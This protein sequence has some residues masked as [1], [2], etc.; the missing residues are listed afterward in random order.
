MIVLQY[1]NIF[2]ETTFKQFFKERNVHKPD[3]KSVLLNINESS[4]FYVTLNLEENSAD[5]SKRVES[6]KTAYLPQDLQLND[7]VRLENIES[8]KSTDYI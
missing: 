8:T 5:Y 6:I 7:E 4:D 1:I 3:L 2:T